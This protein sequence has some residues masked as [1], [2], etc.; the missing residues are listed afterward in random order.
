MAT[1]KIVVA[2]CGQR[3][4]VEPVELIAVS[5]E[6][7][8]G[9]A[10]AELKGKQAVCGAVED[11]EA[12]VAREVKRSELVAVAIKGLEVR[13]SRGA[14]CEETVLH[15]KQGLQGREPG[16]VQHLK[17]VVAAINVLEVG[18]V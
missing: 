5:I 1:A 14:K 4:K 7:V 8:E 3:G 13:H 6:G 10:A 2:Q 18:Q 12:G 16:E 15:R 9:F 17:I 11:M